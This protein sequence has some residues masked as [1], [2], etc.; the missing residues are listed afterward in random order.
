MIEGGSK[1]NI[2]N[3]TWTRNTRAIT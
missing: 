3:I 2:I 1:N